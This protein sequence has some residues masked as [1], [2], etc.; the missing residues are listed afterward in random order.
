MLNSLSSKAADR[1]HLAF[2]PKTHSAYAS[3]FRTFV[4][5][6]I[7]TKA[8]IV[9]VNVK[10]V[11]SFLECLVVNSCSYCMVAN[12]VSTIKANCVL[13]DL[14]FH[15]LNHPQ[16][17]YFPKALKINRPLK[18]KS[19]NVITIPW[20]IEI[21]KVCEGFTSGLIYRAAFRLLWLFMTFKFGT[22]CSC[23]LRSHQTPYWSRWFLHQNIC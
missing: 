7:Y 16:V 3:M 22:S 14:P 9:N 17:K 1:L 21:S 6:C 10:V 19:N 8:C 20:L 5:F 12:Y 15:V 18:V 4:A 2:R 11:L 13:Y 23:W